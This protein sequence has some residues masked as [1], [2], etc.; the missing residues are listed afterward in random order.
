[1]TYEE[2]HAEV[3]RRIHSEGGVSGLEFYKQHKEDYD[4]NL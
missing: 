4:F 1:M 2:I 3:I